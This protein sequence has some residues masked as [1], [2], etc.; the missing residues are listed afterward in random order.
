MNP[1]T[2]HCVAVLMT[3]FNRREKTL[4]CLQRLSQQE[5]P[6][7]CRLQVYLVDDGC[8][9]GTAESVTDLHPQVR[10]IPGNGSLYWAGGMR[11]AWSVAETDNPDYF[12]LLNDDTEIQPHAIATLLDV[13]TR[14]N[15]SA[16]AVAAIADPASSQLTYGAYL[17]GSPGILPSDAHHD[18]CSTFNGNCV[19]IPHAV[20][21]VIGG[22]DP[23]F[24]HSM[25]DSDYGLRAS[26]AGIA[27]IQPRGILGFCRNN[28]AAGTWKDS[29]L[30]RLRRLKLSQRPTALPWR[31]WLHYCRKHFPTTW[32]RH[33]ASPYLRIIIGK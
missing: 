12:L 28:P 10:V 2:F 26:A 9:D 20:A 3:C 16:I 31:D 14:H 19:L 22:L 13:V 4:A 15:D 8:T 11:L 30:S 25:A 23:R 21:R 33:F 32:P 5:L 24:T 1:A 17:T 29:S 18:Q 27:I 6:A 7:G